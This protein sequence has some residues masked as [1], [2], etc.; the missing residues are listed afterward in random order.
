MKLSRIPRW[1]VW[2][3]I[4]VFA[5]TCLYWFIGKREDAALRLPDGR[6]MRVVGVTY[7][8]N[9]VF[10]Y[11]PIWGRLAARVGAVNW[12]ARL[13][14]RSYKVP[15]GTSTTSL[16]VW[17]RSPVNTTNPVSGYASVVDARG[18]ESFQTAT[19]RTPRHQATG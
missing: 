6:I 11:G 7:G 14:Y 13:G 17:M 15:A 1:G 18:A 19:L 9:H 12:A 5:C 8:T 4:F 10:E 16:M 2:A 3:T